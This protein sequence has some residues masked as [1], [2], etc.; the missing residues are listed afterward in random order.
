VFRAQGAFATVLLAIVSFC[1]TP[2]GHRRRIP[3]KFLR[4]P[5]L[6]EP[7]RKNSSPAQRERIKCSICR[8]GPC[9]ASTR[10]ARHTAI[11]CVLPPPVATCAATAG[12]HSATFR[13]RL[14]RAY[15]CVPARWAVTVRQDDRGSR[16]SRASQGQ[17]APT[18]LGRAVPARQS[19]N[20]R[21]GSPQRTQRKAEKAQQ[22]GIAVSFPLEAVA[23]RF[24]RCSLR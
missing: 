2:Q 20:Q 10:S 9:S 13:R 18:Q 14:A 1:L 22:H 4:F 8:V 3:A 21:Q 23:R 5:R 24:S 15:G 12:R 17:L 19:R 7:R 6:R 11:G 16:H